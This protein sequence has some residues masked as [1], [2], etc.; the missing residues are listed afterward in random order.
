[1][2]L[3]HLG[4]RFVIIKNCVNL[5]HV[6][7]LYQDDFVTLISVALSL[8]LSF[9]HAGCDDPVLVHSRTTAE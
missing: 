4:G 8:S 5:L 9:P 3:G 1:M 6:R 2:D 7:G